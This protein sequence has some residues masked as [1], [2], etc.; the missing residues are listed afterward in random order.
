MLV[1]SLYWSGST[2]K[3][4]LTLETQLFWSSG[5]ACPQW[6]KP[7]GLPE[8]WPNINTVIKQSNNNRVCMREVFAFYLLRYKRTYCARN[9]YCFSNMQY[10]VPVMHWLKTECGSIDFWRLFW[11]K[12]SM[13]SKAQ[14]YVYLNCNVR[15]LS[16]SPNPKGNPPWNVAIW[17]KLTF[18]S[19][20]L[21]LHF[22][23]L[24]KLLTIG[25]L[26]PCIH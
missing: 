24:S 2:N 21:G 8:I 14:K 3:S 6:P 18:F 7:K 12:I 22:K 23:G 17:F 13:S 16:H 25:I 4:L 20:S 1:L 10:S 19:H 11:C 9:P 5:Q 15:P 26:F